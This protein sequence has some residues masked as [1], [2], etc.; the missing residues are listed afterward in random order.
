MV[1]CLVAGMGA[2]AV[3]FEQDVANQVTYATELF[4]ATSDARAIQYPVTSDTDDTRLHPMVTLTAKAAAV[5]GTAQQLGAGESGEITFSLSSGAQFATTVGSDALTFLTA[6]DASAG[7]VSIVSGGAKG[8]SSVTFGVMVGET[9]AL[10]V[11][12]TLKF[13]VPRIQNLS[14][15]GSPFTNSVSI[16][17]TARRTGGPGTLADNAHPFPTGEV[18]GFNGTDDNHDGMVNDDDD[19]PATMDTPN[20]CGRANSYGPC[21]V[22][23]SDANAVTLSLNDTDGDTPGVQ[24]AMRTGDGSS[25]IAIDGRT[26]L[27]ANSWGDVLRGD[28]G[29]YDSNTRAVVGQPF[30]A[31]I[32]DLVLTVNTASAAGTI[33]Q[34]DGMPVDNDIAG[35]LNVMVTGYFSEGDMAFVNFNE[36]ADFRWDGYGRRMIDS[37]EALTLDADMMEFSFTTGGLS[38]DP[39]DVITKGSTSATRHLAVYYIP[40]GK[41]ELSHG[42]TVGL[43]AMINYTPPTAQDES[44]VRSRTELRYHGVAGEIQA[45]AIPFEGNGKGDTGNVR[46]R[47]ESGDAFS[48]GA[49]CRAFLEC[50]DD[51]GM[52]AFGEVKPAIPARGLKT[53]QT[54][55]IEM[56]VGATDPTSRHSCRVL[57]TGDASV[58]VLVRDGSSGTLVNNTTVNN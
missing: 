38:I 53:V 19:D 21:R 33:Y 11:G 9:A 10:D 40:A 47:C 7:T 34:W 17:A 44:A 3:K 15:L 46:I 42:S 36:T 35:V 41:E 20:T 24:P 29:P 25:R 52:R 31:P 16:S 48:D 26:M 28:E 22:I 58:Q 37:G 51:M 50:W 49:E 39:D 13:T 54:G 45:Y 12:A 2:W 8:D 6:A 55:D 23:I 57:A 43:S 32:G 14:A 27:V 4:G 5:E 18:L 30:A 1:A 56:I